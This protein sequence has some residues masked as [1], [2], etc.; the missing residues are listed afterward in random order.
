MDNCKHNN[1]KRNCYNCFVESWWG[2]D[3]DKKP[4]DTLNEKLSELQIRIAKLEQYKLLQDDMNTNLYQKVNFVD[5]HRKSQIN[6]NRAVSKHFDILD[7]R[8]TELSEWTRKEEDRIHDK[9]KDVWHAIDHHAECGVEQAKQMKD[10]TLRIC[11][12][13]KANEFVPFEESDY[14]DEPKTSGLTFEEA[15]GYFI[16]G[17]SIQYF[18]GITRGEL[19]TPHKNVAYFFDYNLMLTSHWEVIE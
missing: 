2:N 5:E 7:V 6:E 11:E 9:I 18:D 17:K 1:I 10:L 8:V 15:I 14:I 13:E 3:D 16:K 19:Y 4:M 12:L